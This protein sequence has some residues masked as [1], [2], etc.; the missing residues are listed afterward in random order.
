[1]TR[2]KG[3]IFGNKDTKITQDHNTDNENKIINDSGESSEIMSEPNGIV[4]DEMLEEKSSG[5]EPK[6]G[7]AV[8]TEETDI[9]AGNQFDM[10][11]QS[12]FSKRLMNFRINM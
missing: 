6:S 8:E 11:K 2:D 1:M 4:T 10:K 5:N 7:E 12:E 9:N 3:N